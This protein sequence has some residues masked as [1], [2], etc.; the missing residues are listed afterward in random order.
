MKK[1]SHPRMHDVEAPED[2]PLFRC[3]A[4]TPAAPDGEAWESQVL[5]LADELHER[6][7]SLRPSELRAAAEQLGMIPHHPN[8]WGVIWARLR[9]S[10][11]GRTSAEVASGTTTRNSARESVW[12][13]PS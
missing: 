9:V 11:W 10:G 4:A 13:K 12:R 7:G 5:R 6:L 2:L 3:D 8:R 1:I